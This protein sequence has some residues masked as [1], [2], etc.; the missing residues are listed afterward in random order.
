MFNW[1]QKKHPFHFSTKKWLLFLKIHMFHMCC[2]LYKLIYLYSLFFTNHK[3]L[4]LLQRFNI[5]C[6]SSFEDLLFCSFCLRPSYSLLTK[7]DSGL[8]SR[9]SR[10]TP[11]SS[12]R[13]RFLYRMLLDDFDQMQNFKMRQYLCK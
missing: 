2:E 11:I 4:L 3:K 8:A 5:V 10:L 7:T 1:V 13:L 12:R 6:S 9:V